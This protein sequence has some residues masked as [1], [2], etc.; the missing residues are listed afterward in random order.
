MKQNEEFKI[1]LK[2]IMQK[3]GLDEIAL[4]QEITLAISLM[5][6]SND[7]DLQNFWTEIPCKNNSP[8]IDEMTD[9]LILKLSHNDD[10]NHFR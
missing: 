8:T 2:K 6:K 1:A 10:N 3:E 7:H 9:Y 5:L 4:R